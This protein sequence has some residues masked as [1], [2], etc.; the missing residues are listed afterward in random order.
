MG[1]ARMRQPH[2]IKPTSDLFPAA[3]FV[4]NSNFREPDIKFLIEINISLFSS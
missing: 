3:V 2:L 1:E 4:K